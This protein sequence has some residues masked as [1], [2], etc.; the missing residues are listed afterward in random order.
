MF[1]KVT[2]SLPDGKEIVLEA[3]G[4]SKDNY[5]I[6]SVSLNG[7]AWTR[8]YLKHSDLIRGARIR[9]KMSP[10][11]DTTRGTANVDR[12]YSFSR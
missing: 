2:V 9:Y 7:K 11:P 1:R 10:A 3:P 12:P 4:N 8:N 5:Y 6:S